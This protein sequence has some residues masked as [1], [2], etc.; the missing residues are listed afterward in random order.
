MRKLKTFI[1]LLIINFIF[2][3]SKFIYTFIN[4]NEERNE[5]ECEN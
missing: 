2:N 5:R 1:Y 3:K 4:E